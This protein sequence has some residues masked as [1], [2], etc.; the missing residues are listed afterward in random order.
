MRSFS[1][2]LRS[3]IAHVYLPTPCRPPRGNRNTEPIGYAHPTALSCRTA[4][5]TSVPAPKC[6]RQAPPQS[7]GNYGKKRDKNCS[8][9]RGD[10]NTAITMS[11]MISPISPPTIAEKSILYH[12]TTPLS[13]MM[14][15][16]SAI[17]HKNIIILGRDVGNN[18]PFSTKLTYLWMSRADRLGIC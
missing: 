7:R 10:P 9:A 12:M 13:A 6:G 15:T 3:V 17:S 11:M 2:I 14:K 18:V 1:P 5:D 8:I 4:W 16:A